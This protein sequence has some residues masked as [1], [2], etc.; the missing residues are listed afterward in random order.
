MN[1]ECPPKISI[2]TVAFNAVALLE[3]TIKNVEGQDYPYVEHIIVDGNS[4]DG[5]PAML[6]KYTESRDASL[7]KHEI[8]WISEP[9][10]G[11]YDAMNKAIRMA[12]G[13]YLLFLNA[14]D[15]L[16]SKDT[17]SHIASVAR[18]SERGTDGDTLPAVVYGHT[19]IV[20]ANGRFLHARRLVPPEHLSWKSFRR[21][22]LVCHQAFFARTDIARETPYDLQYR[23][24]ADF[25]WCVRIMRRAEKENLPLANAHIVVADYLEGGLTVKNH[26]RSL[27]ERF[28]IMTRHYGLLTTLFE[29]VFFVVRN[30][31]KPNESTA[32]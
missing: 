7:N 23:F 3:K 10:N 31:K 1:N 25:D 14:G 22:M 11:L 30:L 6:Q 16:H 29:H 32:L 18:Q 15:K 17:L 9:D 26:R 27:W 21:G 2:A 24:S 13:N 28:R 20:D 4:Q 19:N 12:T 8:R 5:T